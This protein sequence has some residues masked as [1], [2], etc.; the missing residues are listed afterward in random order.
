MPPIVQDP[1][2]SVKIW[3]CP[4]TDP[5]CF[6]IWFR[7]R[8]NINSGRRQIASRGCYLYVVPVGAGRS[9]I[10]DISHDIFAGGKTW[11]GWARDWLAANAPTGLIRSGHEGGG[12]ASRDIMN[13]HISLL[14]HA[15]KIQDGLFVT[16]AE[17]HRHA[18][19]GNK[20][21]SIRYLYA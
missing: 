2:M 6:L 13:M 18:N 9:I 16:S 19:Q 8:L 21:W 1:H 10:I 4:L 17:R 5:Y 20:A 12:M 11:E 14:C 3:E 15:L 7:G